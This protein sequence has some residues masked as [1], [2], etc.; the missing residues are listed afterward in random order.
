ML[1]KLGIISLQTVLGNE[2]STD[3]TRKGLHAITENHV[4]ISSHESGVVLDQ[5]I[6]KIS[7]S[8]FSGRNGSD[9]S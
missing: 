5:I 2:V 6:S 8:V 3:V 4:D 7:V 9:F 1:E